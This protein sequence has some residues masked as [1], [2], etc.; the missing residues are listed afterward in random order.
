MKNIK[1]I[2]RKEQEKWILATLI[3]EYESKFF[4]GGTLHIILEDDNFTD[5]AIK[6]CHELSRREGNDYM[7]SMICELLQPL[8]EKEREYV[9]FNSGD[10]VSVFTVL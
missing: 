10:I 5:E 9:C 1:D 6:F 4:T 3:N 2:P 7:A 8:T